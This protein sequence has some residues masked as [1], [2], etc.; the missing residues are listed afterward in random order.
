[1]PTETPLEAS[2]PKVRQIVFLSDSLMQLHCPSGRE[3]SAIE[4]EGLLKQA[5]FTSFQVVVQVGVDY[6]M[7]AF[8]QVST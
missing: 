4:F 8:K 5:G 6:V 2:V 7:E 1:M 3:R